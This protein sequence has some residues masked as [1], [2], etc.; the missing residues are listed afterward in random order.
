MCR[1]DVEASSNG[2]NIIKIVLCWASSM[3]FPKLYIWLHLWGRWFPLLCVEQETE[4]LTQQNL[5]REARTEFKAVQRQISSQYVYFSVPVDNRRQMCYVNN[6]FVSRVDVCLSVF[7]SQETFHE[8]KVPVCRS[9]GNPQCCKGKY[10][11][12]VR[13]LAPSCSK[14]WILPAAVH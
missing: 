2:T 6:I 7:N 14:Q 13:I 1:H 8:V 10:T 4:L 3:C 9:F 12:S 5:S 11:S